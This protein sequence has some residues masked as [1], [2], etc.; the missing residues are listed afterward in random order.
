MKSYTIS[1][2][3]VDLFNR[4]VFCGEVQVAH[5]RI[6]KIVE[7]SIAPSVFILPGLIDA[8]VHIESSMLTPSRFARLVV[9]H[10]TVAVVSDPHEI[11]NVMGVAGVRFM[12][13][14]GK[15]VPLKF[16][17]GAPSCV[18]A[19]PFEASGA[20]LNARAID[21][22]LH[23]PDIWFLSEMMNFPGVVSG[24]QEVLGKLDA[25]KRLGLKID[26]H[27]PGLTGEALK[28]YVSAGIETDHECASVDEAL[29][30]IALGMK[31][32]IREGSAA[33]NFESLAPLFETHPHAIML[34]T[35]D[36]HPDE[37]LGSGHINRLIKLGL[38]LGVDVFSLLRAATINP[39]LHYNLPVG[40]LR[41]GDDADFIVVDNLEDI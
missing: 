21:A 25:A 24:D 14:D 15:R 27:A 23:D 30:K 1:G 41:E 19:T 12:V 3:I 40:L 22:L 17:F 9:P 34:C 28:K 4:R 20:E 2:N 8:H 33:R 13:E 5:G 29:E 18:P 26:G 11:A 7:R 16:F 10:G 32:Q 35:D 31:I 6:Q 37:I 39:V 38:T 36:S